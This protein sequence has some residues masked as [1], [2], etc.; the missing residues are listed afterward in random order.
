MRIPENG[1]RWW[2]EVV[3]NTTPGAGLEVLNGVVL[4]FHHFSP[5]KIGGSAG[6]L[7]GEREHNM[8][9]S[10]LVG[11]S[12]VWTGFCCAGLSLDGLCMCR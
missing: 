11:P 2:W 1:E 12:S 4:E 6:S 8:D 3:A 10:Y 9:W 7:L 5:Q